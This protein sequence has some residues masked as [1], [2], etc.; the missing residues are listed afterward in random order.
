MMLAFFL[1]YLPEM[2]AQEQ[3]LGFRSGVN[4][5]SWA[6]SSNRT[7]ATLE[8]DLGLSLG[9][10]YTVELPDHNSIQAE[11]N[12]SQ[13]KARTIVQQKRFRNYVKPGSQGSFSLDYIEAPVFIRFEFGNKFKG[14]GSL[15]VSPS[16]LIHV[17]QESETRYSTPSFGVE[18]KDK[19]LISHD[20]FNEFKLGIMFGFGFE[21]DLGEQH[22]IVDL[23][24]TR[25]FTD[26]VSNQ[27][28]NLRTDNIADLW[29]N[30]LTLSIGY[31]FE[32]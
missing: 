19:N 30:T 6:T 12:Y 27:G 21:V 8:R 24:T 29:M 4:R 13:H 15:G 17:R 32:L 22:L 23:K 18:I 5:S 28:L 7:T 16:F 10:V 14:F 25:G 11:L 20:D 26:L 3:T 31:T 2:H 1:C 9:L